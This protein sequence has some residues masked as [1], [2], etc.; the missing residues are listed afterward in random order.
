MG[1]VRAVGVVV[2]S[3]GLLAPAGAAE[4]YL[5]L[6]GGF[7]ASS[8]I[9]KGY[10]ESNAEYSG[11]ALT[12]SAALTDNFG[13]RVNLFWT[14]NDRL[15][16]WESNGTDIQLLGGFNLA[17]EGFKAYVSLGFFRDDWVGPN[18]EF[19]SYSGGQFGV[20]LGYNWEPV[21]LDLAI[22]FRDASDYEAEFLMPLNA[23]SSMLSLGLRF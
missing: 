8:M 15:Y 6:G 14:D 22:N 7:Y 12:G 13:L 17:S 10:T 18:E 11:L 21:T 16:G 5:S 3:L 2:V 9:Q 4:K 19:T 23:T 20:G 1:V